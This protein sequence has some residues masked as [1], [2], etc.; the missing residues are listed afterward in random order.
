MIDPDRIPPHDDLA[1]KSVLGL[2]V[3]GS[4]RPRPPGEDF[5]AMANIVKADDFYTPAHA[6][7]WRALGEMADAG[8]PLEL[9]A[10]AA[11]LRATGLLGA[12]GRAGGTDD[13]GATYL[14][15]LVQGYSFSTANLEYYAAQI[16]DHA[17]RR[18]KIIEH[19]RLAEEAWDPAC[20]V[21]PEQ[22]RPAAKDARPFGL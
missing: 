16:R 14:T 5:L 20:P 17:R 10:I 7:L 15:E 19:T 1:E 11:H 8:K 2:A 22:R 3:G 12:I 21:E 4:D 18:A 13:D 9:G 6:V